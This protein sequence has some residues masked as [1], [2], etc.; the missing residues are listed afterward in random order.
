MAPERLTKAEAAHLLLLVQRYYG[1]SSYDRVWTFNH[2][3]RHFD[4][5][6]YLAACP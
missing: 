6:G 1:T 2:A 4:L 5:D 3:E